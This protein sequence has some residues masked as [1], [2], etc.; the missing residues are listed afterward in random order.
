MYI[1]QITGSDLALFT[2]LEDYFQAYALICQPC[3]ASVPVHILLTF[4]THIWVGG[5]VVNKSY[6]KND[7]GYMKCVKYPLLYLLYYYKVFSWQMNVKFLIPQ[8]ILRA[9]YYISVRC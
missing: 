4:I 7:L 1:D 3:L 5:T 9:P 6:T 8:K 2:Q